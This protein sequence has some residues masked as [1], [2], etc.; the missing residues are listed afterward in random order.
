MPYCKKIRSKSCF[1]A[2]K[3]LK[4]D[5]STWNKSINPRLIEANEIVTITEYPIW[6]NNFYYFHTN[7]QTQYKGAAGTNKYAWL[8][9]N[10]RECT[11]YGCNVADSSTD[12]Y[13]T[14]TVNSEK[15]N[16]AWYVYHFGNL[17]SLNFVNSAAYGVRPVI[18]VSRS[19]IS[20]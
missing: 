11:T 8:F 5:T 17:F 12:G 4:S 10:T 15:S 18:T 7:S 20:K 16:R 6:D 2:L 19:I 13:W 14:S 1:A 3:Q 9:D